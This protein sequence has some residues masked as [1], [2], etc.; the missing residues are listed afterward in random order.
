MGHTDGFER[1][2]STNI[3]VT[4]VITAMV[5]PFSHVVVETNRLVAITEAMLTMSLPADGDDPCLG[6][7]AGMSLD[8][9]FHDRFFT[10]IPSE[11][12]SRKKGPLQTRKKNPKKLEGEISGSVGFMKRE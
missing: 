11:L 2:T 4:G 9:G 10:T 3:E 6:W 8:R 7:W 1:F 5:T 12:G